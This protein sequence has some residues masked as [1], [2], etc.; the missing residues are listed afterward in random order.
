MI[1]IEIHGQVVGELHTID[2][3]SDQSIAE[4]VKKTTLD[5]L[6]EIRGDQLITIDSKPEAIANEKEKEEWYKTDI[7]RETR[8]EKRL[9]KA[10]RWCWR[11]AK[12]IRQ[13]VG[14]AT[15]HHKAT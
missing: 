2:I 12:R 7:Y 14:K 4:W 11:M 9:F 1:K 6:Q 8:Q 3:L 10:K 13:A 5:H 15:D